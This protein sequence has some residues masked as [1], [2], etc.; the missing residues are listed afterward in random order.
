M[1]KIPRIAAWQNTYGA[2]GLQI[3]GVSLDDSDA[4]VKRAYEKYH[5]N[6]PAV[7]GDAELGERFCGVPGLPLSYRIDPEGRI[8]GWVQGEL[9]L[10]QLKLQIK[11][12]LP[13]P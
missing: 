8:V 1:A 12:L 10:T 6:H 7:M 9:N 2:S 4:P 13:R 5:L 3:V 11:S